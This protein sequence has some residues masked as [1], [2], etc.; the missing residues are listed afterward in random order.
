MSLRKSSLDST[1]VELVDDNTK[2]VLETFTSL[3]KASRILGNGG[4]R[5]STFNNKVYRRQVMELTYKGELKKV[6]FR[7]K[8]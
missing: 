2:K 4:T 7:E 6:F 5:S 8:L 1:C 3:A